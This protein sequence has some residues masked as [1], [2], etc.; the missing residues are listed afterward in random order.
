[1][2]TRSKSP[3]HVSSGAEVATVVWCRNGPAVLT[4]SA[5]PTTAPAPTSRCSPRS[6]SGR[7]ACS[8]TTGPS[9]GGADR[10]RRLRLARLPAGVGPGQRYGYRVHGPYDPA[11]GH[12]C[13]PPSCCSTRTP[14]PIEGQVDGDES[15]FGYQFGDAGRAQ[16]RSTPAR[17]TMPSVVI[18]PF[19][20]WGNDRP[21]RHA[22]PRDGDLR[23]ARQG[24]D[25]DPPGDARGAS[26]APTPGSAHPAIIEHLTALGVTAVELM[27]VHQ[28]VQDD[29]LL[30]ARPAQL[31]GLQH[32]RLLRPAQRLRRAAARAASRCRSSRRWCKALHA[33]GIEVILDVVYNHTAEGNHLGPTLSFRGIDNAVVLPARR[34][35]PAHYYDTTGTGNTLLMR[36]PHV[37]QLIMDSL[38]Y[39]VT[40]MHV[41]GFRFDLAATLARQFHEVDRLSAFFDLVQQDPV[42]S[43]GQADRRAVGRRRGR[44]PGRQLPAAVD[45]VER[46]VPRHRARLLARR[47]AHAR[48]VRLPAHRLV[49]PLPGRRPPP[50]RV[51]STSSPRTT[52]SP[53]ATWSPTT[54]ST[55]R[56]TART[57]ATARATTGPGTAASRARP[58]TRRSSRC[59]PGSSATSSPRCCSRRACRCSLHGDELGR[60]QGG[61]NNAYCQDNELAWVDWELDRASSWTLLEFTRH[62]RRGCAASTRSSGAAASSTGDPTP[63]PRASSA[64]SPGSRPDGEQMSDERLAASAY[65]R[66]G[67]GVPQR[68]RDR[69]AG[70]RA[71][72][73]SST[74]RSCCCSTATTRRMDFTAARE[75]YGERWQC[76]AGHRGRPVGGRRGRAAKAGEPVTVWSRGRHRWC[77]DRGGLSGPCRTRAG[78]PTGHLP[79][80]AARRTSASTTPPRSLPY[81]HGL[82]VSHVYLSPVLQ[83][84]PGS[85]HGYD[86][87]DH[88]PP[89]NEA[90]GGAAGVRPARGTAAACARPGR[91]RRRRAEP[92]GGADA[93][94]AQRGAVVGAARRAG[95]A[96]RPTGSTSTGRRRNAPLL[97]P[98]LGQRIGEVLADGE[99]TLDR[100]TATSRAALLRPR[101]PGAAGHRGPAAARSCSTGSATGWRTGGSPT[102]S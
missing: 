44:L 17:H 49:R 13:N 88:T 86:V 65:A 34:R 50:A 98:V 72:S 25:D 2:N 79:A 76:R 53:C 89:V 29:H 7:S 85:T 48:R 22:V 80:P 81:L 31:L 4:R 59:A 71:A 41:D 96:V 11:R 28:F 67:R 8:T 51:A 74:T 20:D 61:N 64:T 62:A 27:P 58:T 75:E 54:T 43:P 9:R 56:P 95:L 82:G 78:V 1:M 102:R 19:F 77:C 24:P 69:R 101:V 84:A 40:E 35:R 66:V 68:R 73:G 94:L 37:L 57:T 55:T 47:A 15:L 42:V 23:G 39:W 10:G 46:Q 18:N 16:H 99:I 100:S 70:P 33:A 6:P 3:R 45:R 63:G 36:H 93:R 83:A 26:A 91:R 14:R 12:R 5:P 21:P 90:L 97:M 32:D 38:R 30:R 87:V 52:A 60:T 92:H